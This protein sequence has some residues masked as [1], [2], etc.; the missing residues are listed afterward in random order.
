MAVLE[1]QE[2]L[3]NWRGHRPRTDTSSEYGP[4]LL[5]VEVVRYTHAN[6]IDH[7]DGIQRRGRDEHYWAVFYTRPHE[8]LGNYATADEAKAAAEANLAAH[9]APHNAG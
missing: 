5:A 4:G 2:H 7:P 1:W 9:D 6:W 3:G 8:R